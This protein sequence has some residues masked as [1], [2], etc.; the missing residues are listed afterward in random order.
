VLSEV[1]PSVDALRER[2]RVEERETLLRALADHG[3]NI[4]RAAQSLGRS[5]AALYRL[6][7]KHGIALQRQRA[8]GA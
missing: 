1:R 3:G 8:A 4:A 6:A 2:H 7:E 5:R